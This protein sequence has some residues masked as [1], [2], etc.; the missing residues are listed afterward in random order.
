MRSAFRLR[1]LAALAAVGVAALTLAG[2]SGGGPEGPGPLVSIPDEDPTATVKVLTVFDLEAD[3]LQ[4]V[5]DAG[6]ISK[7][8]L[9]TV[10]PVAE[11]RDLVGAAVTATLS[12][13]D[14]ATELKKAHDQFRPIL[15]RSEKAT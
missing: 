2:C 11:W 1:P 8:G 10:I 15:E 5:I 13:A 3:G 7:L 6:K 9:P 12:G 14:P 4:S